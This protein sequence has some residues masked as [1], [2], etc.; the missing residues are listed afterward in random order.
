MK[1]GI[2]DNYRT[3]CRSLAVDPRDGSV[4]F[5]TGDGDILRY[6]FESEL[7]E[8]V[9]NA[10]LRKDYFGK[11]EVTSPGHMAYNWRQTIWC[12]AQN[13]IYGVHGNSGYLFRFT[14]QPPDL[15]L[16]QRITSEPSQRS[17]MFDQFSYGYL[18]FTL[19][20][21]GDTI[22]YLTGGPVYESGKRVK[23]KDS[24]SMGEAK[25]IENLHLIT[26]NIPER[27]YKDHGPVFYADGQRPLY[28]NSIAVG[29]D[30][31]I[32]TL[33]R[34]T[35]NGQTRTDLIAIPDLS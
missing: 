19:G 23:G 11:Y 31:V 9:N 29:K 34:I 14:P 21:D 26:Y 13:A 30:G 5:T 20:P 1:Y 3:L 15:E 27:K 16:L 18:G 10:D 28:V 12:D 22:Y 7:V 32:Y 25:G 24:T 2:G 4:Y 17:G 6:D 8:I 33:A 35:E